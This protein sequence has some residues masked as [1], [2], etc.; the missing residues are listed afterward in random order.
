[1]HLTSFGGLMK[2]FDRFIYGEL[3]KLLDTP[4]DEIDVQFGNVN[5]GVGFPNPSGSLPFMHW[6]RGPRPYEYPI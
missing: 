4:A 5:V 2:F 1:M 3:L 6:A